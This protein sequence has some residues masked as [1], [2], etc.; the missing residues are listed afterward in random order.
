CFAR[1]S[2]PQE[3]W[4]SLA[5]NRNVAH[6]S[7]GLGHR[8]LKAEITGSNPV[9][10]TTTQAPDCSGAC[11]IRQQPEPGGE[12]PGSQRKPARAGLGV[13]RSRP[14]HLR[15]VILPPA[16]RERVGGARSRSA[17]P[18]RPEAP[19]ATATSCDDRLSRPLVPQRQAL[20]ARVRAAEERAGFGVHLDDLCR[21]AGSPV[22]QHLD[23][24]TTRSEERR[25]GKE[26]RLRGAAQSE[27][28][29]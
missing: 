1:H 8:P 13:R 12:P 16:N 2:T 20:S 18:V 7:S 4:Y 28:T 10:A 27:N 22:A 25:V 19:R 15:V 26:G 11:C 23:A 9:C 24:V 29:K 3:L 6:S 14:P 17:L 21:P 5:D